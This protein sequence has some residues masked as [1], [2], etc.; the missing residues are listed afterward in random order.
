MLDGIISAKVTSKPF[1]AKK[2]PSLP[3]PH[4]KSKIFL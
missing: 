3:R 1:S 2:I 4:P